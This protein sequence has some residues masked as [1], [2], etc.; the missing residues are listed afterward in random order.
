MRGSTSSA[1]ARPAITVAIGATPFSARSLGSSRASASA[2]RS[3][4]VTSSRSASA[5]CLRASGCS[6]SWRAA[7]IASTVVTTPASVQ[8]CETS[9][10]FSSICIIGAGSARP[11]VSTTMRLNGGISPASRLASSS[12]SALSRSER[13]VQQTQPLCSTT[14]SPSIASTSRWSSPTAPNS[15]TITAVSPSSGCF[16]RWFSSVVL[17]LPRKPVSTV[18]GTRSAERSNSNRLKGVS[19]SR[20]LDRDHE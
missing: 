17:P 12:R 5:T 6:S 14:I 19:S 16:S 9:G 13:S 2:S 11:V 1:L 18:T 10:L 20:R 15:L 7:L 3:V 4:L 8:K